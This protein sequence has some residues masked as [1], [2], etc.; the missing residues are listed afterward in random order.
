MEVHE[1]RSNGEGARAPRASDAAANILKCS[2]SQVRSWIEV[3]FIAAAGAAA[4]ALTQLST[5]K[6][7]RP[8]R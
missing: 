4:A 1:N 5:E 8:W 7:L 3:L 6:L 2:Q